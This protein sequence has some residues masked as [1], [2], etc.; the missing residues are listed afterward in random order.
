MNLVGTQGSGSLPDSSLP[1]ASGYPTK[2]K[3]AQPEPS[4][5]LGLG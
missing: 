5:E 4:L 2:Q 3:E 1:I